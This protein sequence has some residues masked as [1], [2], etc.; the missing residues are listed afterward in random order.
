MLLAEQLHVSG[1]R[2]LLS[3]TSSGSITPVADPPHFVLIDRALRDEGTS[4][5]YM[6]PALW[7]DAPARLL[8]SGMASL[9][10]SA[11]IG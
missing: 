10:P 3:I 1:C 2:L 11:M 8:A 4:H 9:S 6:P 7:S 5:H